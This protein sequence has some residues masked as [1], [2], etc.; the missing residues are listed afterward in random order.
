MIDIIKGK[1]QSQFEGS[2]PPPFKNINA[3]TTT[4][5]SDDPYAS[6]FLILKG[7]LHTAISID[8]P[9]K[10]LAINIILKPNWNIQIVGKNIT[11]TRPNSI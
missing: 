4:E 3:T 5:K 10:I 7:S 11:Q 2:D 8:N 1:N 9:S 6:D